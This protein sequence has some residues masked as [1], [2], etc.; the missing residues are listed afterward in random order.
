MPEVPRRTG[1]HSM[2]N[3]Q[4]ASLTPEALEQIATAVIDKLEEI[5]KTPSRKEEIP[6]AKQPV[7]S[8]AMCKASAAPWTEIKHTDDCPICPACR[9]QAAKH[10]YEL[11]LCNSS[12]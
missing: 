10:T 3:V 2:T 5:A 1:E 6:A 7:T 8:C 4:V 9:G 11:E 12:P